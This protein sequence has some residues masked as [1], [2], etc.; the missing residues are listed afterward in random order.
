MRKPYKP[1]DNGNFLSQETKK[2][3]EMIKLHYLQNVSAMRFQ[4]VKT[5]KPI[6]NEVFKM[7]NITIHYL[8]QPDV[9]ENLLTH[10]RAMLRKRVQKALRL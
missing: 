8:I 1:I 2:D 6:E 9:D 4:N 10:F 3:S 7:Q 5:L